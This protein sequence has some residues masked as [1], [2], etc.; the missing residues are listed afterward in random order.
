[1]ARA[2]DSEARHVD[3]GDS[4]LGHHGLGQTGDAVDGVQA[5]VDMCQPPAY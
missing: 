3:E 5:D 2:I 1:M 4:G